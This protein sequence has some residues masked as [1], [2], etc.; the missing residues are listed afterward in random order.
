MRACGRCGESRPER[1]FRVYRQFKHGRV[2][3]YRQVW[4]YECEKE[5][6]RAYHYKMKEAQDAQAEASA[7]D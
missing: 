1:A 6:G 2:Y 3:T 5:Y 7:A 4:C